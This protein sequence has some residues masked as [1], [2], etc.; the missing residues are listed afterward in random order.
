MSARR[1]AQPHARATPP[2]RIRARVAPQ[3]RGR[4][5]RLRSRSSMALRRRACEQP[6]RRPIGRAALVRNLH[7]RVG[8]PRAP[9]SWLASTRSAAKLR[10]LPAVGRRAGIPTLDVAHAE[11]VDA[12]AIEGASY[13]RSAAFAAGAIRALQGRNVAPAAVIVTVG[14]PRFDALH[15][16]TS[17][18]SSLPSDRP[19]RVHVAVGHRSR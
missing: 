16:A 18:G 17:P 2:P 13:D 14:A 9:R 7:R 10:I 4:D 5:R 15:R 3:S 19:T 11:A 12:D 8:S 6:W 1:P